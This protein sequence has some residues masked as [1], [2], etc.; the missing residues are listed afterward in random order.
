V[1]RNHHCVGGH[2]GIEREQAERR[3]AV[4]E[5]ELE[6]IA[7]RG[8]H[9]SQP[10]FTFGER[11]ELDLRACE[12]AIRGNQREP[13]DRRVED[14]GVRRSV[15]QQRLVY[16]PAG[17]PLPFQPD[18][19]REVSLGV[20]VHEQHAMPRQ[21]EGRRHVDGRGRLPD[22]TLLFAT[23]TIRP[24]PWKSAIFVICPICPNMGV[25]IL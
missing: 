14:K 6:S 11:H 13:L 20:N 24:V 15:R 18:A 25:K 22:A 21:G 4:D 12:L 23:A 16:G 19:A 9:A 2:E 17:R 5:D 10:A 1:E 3:R 7:Q 8:Q